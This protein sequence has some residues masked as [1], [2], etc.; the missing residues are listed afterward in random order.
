[1]AQRIAELEK[2]HEAAM[3]AERDQ[4]SKLKAE[5][6]DIKGKHEAE[7][8]EIRLAA[9]NQQKHHEAEMRRLGEQYSTAAKAAA[10]AETKLDAHKA[11][12]VRWQS[13][14]YHI[15]QQFASKPFS[16]ASLSFSPFFFTM[17]VC[18][19]QCRYTLLL[20]QPFFLSVR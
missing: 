10:A 18:F 13:S 1:M 11:D 20:S 4:A 3:K 12:I 2:R 19:L 16:F 14:L 7:I 15:N 8:T 6:Q 5:L 9:S 17:P